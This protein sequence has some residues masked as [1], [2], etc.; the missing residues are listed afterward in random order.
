MMV[1][2][3][4]GAIGALLAVFLFGMWLVWPELLYNPSGF[5]IGYKF[6]AVSFNNEPVLR[7][8]APSIPTLEVRG[9]STFHH[10]VGGT[11]FCN[12]WGG[13]LTLLPGR[14]LAWGEIVKTTL[15][16]DPGSAE[17]Q[18]LQALLGA[19]RWRTEEGILILHNGTDIL[20]FRL[21]P[22]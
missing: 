1:V 2:R 18:Y 4:L 7:R 9:R 6:V 21:A 19:T 11:A 12:A 16:C 17:Q 14:R 5:P 3:F 8:N 15:A 13:H 22:P 20:R 10:R